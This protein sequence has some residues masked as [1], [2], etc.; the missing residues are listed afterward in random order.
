PVPVH[1]QH[2]QVIACSVPATLRCFSS[3][4]ISSSFRKFLPRSCASVVFPTLEFEA[5]STL[6]RLAGL[7]L[8]PENLCRIYS[9]CTTLTA[10]S[11]KCSALPTDLPSRARQQ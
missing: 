2:Q 4:S 11:A 7:F 1:H 6:R 5:L 9:Q 10:K 3:L 8:P